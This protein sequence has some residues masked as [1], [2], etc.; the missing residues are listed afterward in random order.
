MT[1]GDRG[2]LGQDRCF[3]GKIED[4][5]FPIADFRLICRIFPVFMARFGLVEGVLGFLL[6]VSGFLLGGEFLPVFGRAV[7]TCQGGRG[8]K[9]R[10]PL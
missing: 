3:C 7:W 9:G 4:F 2:V 6:P 1:L 8:A 5:L 10:G